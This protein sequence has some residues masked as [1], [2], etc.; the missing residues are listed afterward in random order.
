MDTHGAPHPHE[1]TPAQRRSL[2]RIKDDIGFA[3]H[4]ERELA[5]RRQDAEEKLFRHL[6][7]ERDGREFEDGEPDRT[8]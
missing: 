6:Q 8:L 4:D 7:H 5:R 2:R 1:Q 3:H